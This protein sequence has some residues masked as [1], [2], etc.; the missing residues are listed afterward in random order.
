MAL[1]ELQAATLMSF[2]EHG[3]HVV[4]AAGHA[5]A[6]CSAPCVFT[7]FAVQHKQHVNACVPCVYQRS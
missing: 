2:F 6:Y 7:C 5:F 3:D 1:E 4:H